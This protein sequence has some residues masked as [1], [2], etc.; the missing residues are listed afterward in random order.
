MIKTDKYKKGVI[1]LTQKAAEINPLLGNYETHYLSEDARF[2]VQL[3]NGKLEIDIEMARVC[4]QD[5][6]KLIPG[7]LKKAAFSYREGENIKANASNINTAWKKL[8]AK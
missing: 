6:E 4:E 5:P 7:K 8:F 2:V 3:S 1:V